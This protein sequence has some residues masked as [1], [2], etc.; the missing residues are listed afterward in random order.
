MQENQAFVLVFDITRPSSLMEVKQ[1]F[2]KKLK[3]VHEDGLPPVVLVGNKMDLKAQRKVNLKLALKE[4]T[5]MECCA[6]F[7]ASAKTGE[8]VIR[9]FDKIVKELRRRLRRSTSVRQQQASA[10]KNFFAFC[11]LI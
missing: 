11:S 4:A 8:G 7:E 1:K 2:F 6:Y 5:A 3:E 9:A 10:S